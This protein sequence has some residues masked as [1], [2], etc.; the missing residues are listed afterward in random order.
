MI[1]KLAVAVVLGLALVTLTGCGETVEDIKKEAA[2]IEAC[3]DT[4]GKFSYGSFGYVC[5]HANE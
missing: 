3:H 5:T 2:F 1:R 4:D